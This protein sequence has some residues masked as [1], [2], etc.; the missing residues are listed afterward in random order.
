MRVD[1]TIDRFLAWVARHRSPATHSAYRC[2]L[3]LCRATYGDREFADLTP[4]D[5]EDWLQAAKIKRDGTE[6][7]PDTYRRN[8]VAFLQLQKWARKN[9]ILKRRIV[10]EIEKPT[11][12]L[13]ERV[14]TPEEVAAVLAHA[15]E[16]FRALYTALR[17]CGA[18]P[19]ELARA[20]I[21]DYDAA[22][23]TIV[24]AEHK[25]RSKTHKPRTIPVGAKLAALL[26]EEIGVRIAGPIFRR[27]AGGKW[28]RPWTARTISQTFRRIRERAG[29]PKDLVVYLSRHEYLTKHCEQF[30]I[31]AA[32]EAAGHSDIKTTQ[33]YVHVG[34]DK[35]RTQQDQIDLDAA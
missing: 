27:T 25:T 6:I 10:R 24:L 3:R 26:A 11:G 14:P 28:G 22:A 16:D 5:V 32:A 33:R 21:A 7:A 29:L 13:R 31:K 30:G 12:R 34:T 8:A 4:L 17:L 1:E 18:R 15:P 9:R 23:G 20:T 19:G 35:L 2:G